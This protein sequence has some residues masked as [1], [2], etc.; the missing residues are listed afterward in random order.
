VRA[1]E[2]A[3]FTL[4]AATAKLVAPAPQGPKPATRHG[5]SSISQT[6]GSLLTPLAFVSAGVAAVG[7]GAFGILGASSQADYS[8]LRRKCGDGT[9]PESERERIEGGST[10]QLWANVGL[11]V[12]AV[13]GASA[14]TLWLLMDDTSQGASNS[15]SLRLQVS[16]GRIALQGE[17]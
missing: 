12:G 1:G 14:V 7:F 6:S 4:D 5:E 2:N 10:K 17:L 9:C 13:A 15:A 11:A 16:P 8:E 3:E